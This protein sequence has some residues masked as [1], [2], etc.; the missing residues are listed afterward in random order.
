MEHYFSEHPKSSF[1]PERFNIEILGQN[2]IINSGSGLFSLKELDFGT[3][4]LIE[5]SKIPTNDA[6]VL[7]L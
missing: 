3:G 1:V 6:E 4:L 2:I 7:D 5:N